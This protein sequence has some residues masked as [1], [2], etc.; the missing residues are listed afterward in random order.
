MDEIIETIRILGPTVAVL[1]TLT[2]ASTVLMPQR[3]LNS[4]LLMVSLFVSV[5]F[6]SGFF[7]GEAHA[8]FL[9]AFFLLTTLALMLVPALL[10]ANGIQMIR[11]ESLSLAH[12]LS[13]AL[14]VFVGVGE[15]ATVVYVLA[16]AESLSLANVGPWI[17][18]LSMTVFYFSLLV[19]N[20][21]VYC[22]FIQISPH[23]MNFD[24]VI[25]HGCGLAGGGGLTKLLQGRVDK[26]IEIYGKCNAKPIL[27]P[28]GGQ[29][30]DEEV[31]EARAMADYLVAHGIP[32]ERIVL[33]DRSAT[34]RENLANS[35]S[36]IDARGGG[37]TA[38]VSS[39]Y[40]IYRCLRIARSIGLRCTGIGGKVAPYYWPS[41]IIREFI[42]VFMTKGFLIWA[43]IGYLFFVS[44]VLFALFG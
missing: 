1:W 8:W 9:M 37:K 13:L 11:R 35:K 29:G 14:G 26:A 31:S 7:S 28:S 18:L 12:V 44:P 17:L 23:R 33:E 25:I 40:H 24:Y 2:I 41:A 20:F 5:I 36:I 38:L 30:Q 19:L 15:V 22:I 3:Y 39:S 43:L 4:V 42:A 6:I 21:V 16:L 32:Q 27:I 10:I 34:T